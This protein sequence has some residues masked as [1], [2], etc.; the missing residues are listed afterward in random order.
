MDLGG[1]RIT[2][3]VSPPGAAA[4]EIGASDRAQGAPPLDL[5]EYQGKQFFARYG[6]PVSPGEAVTTADDPTCSSSAVA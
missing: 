2:P 3:V 5:Y 6:I 1:V 4:S